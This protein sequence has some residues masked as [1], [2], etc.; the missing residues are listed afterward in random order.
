MK[1]AGFT[2]AELL[3]S[4]AILGVIATFTIPKV[5]NAQQ[6]SK[7]KAVL[8][9]TLASLEAVMHDGLLTGQF[10]QQ[11][12]GDYILSHLNAVKVCDTDAEA[13]GC[14]TQSS[15][16]SSENNEPGLIMHN[17]VDVAGLNNWTADAWNIVILDWNGADPPN[18]EGQDQLVLL[19]CEDPTGSCGANNRTGTMRP[20]AGYDDSLDLYSEIFSN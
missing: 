4:L 13:Q 16:H 7:R 6:D 8:R 1:K 17:G 5:L 10:S 18:V 11:H 9:E 14:W 2:L 19:M 12:N 3:I 15:P 20:A